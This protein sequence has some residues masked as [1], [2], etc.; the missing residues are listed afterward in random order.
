[1]HWLFVGACKQHSSICL[2]LN[3]KAQKSL[4]RLIIFFL[5]WDHTVSERRCE[6]ESRCD[7]EGEQARKVED[8]GIA[9][10]PQKCDPCMHMH[11]KPI[12]SVDQSLLSHIAPA[13]K[14]K[15]RRAFALIP[16]VCGTADPPQM[17]FTRS[18]EH[19]GE[20]VDISRPPWRQD[21]P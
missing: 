15:D 10:R 2:I 5:P 1:M 4:N 16:R 11:E 3:S 20:V 21:I 6:Q 8:A 13:F 14:P 17:P 7:R 9:V 18:G 19:G 12:T